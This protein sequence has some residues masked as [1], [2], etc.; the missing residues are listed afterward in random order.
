MRNIC[1]LPL[2]IAL[3]IVLT[4][5]PTT[6]VAQDAS[7]YMY[8]ANWGTPK[9]RRANLDGTNIQDLVTGIS[10]PVDIAL[11]LP[12]GKMYWTDRTADDH[13]DPNIMNRI[14]RANLDGTNI[15]TLAIGRSSIKEG[16]ALDLSGGKMYWAVWSVVN[17]ENKIQRANLDGTN[18]EDLVILP[19]ADTSRYTGPRGIALDISQG[20]M[21]WTD[22]G[23]GKIQRA[24]LDGTNIE[25]LV[26]GLGCPHRIA[27]DFSGDKVYWTD[28]D[29]EKI[30]RANLNGSNPEDIIVGLS[31]PTGI[32][33]DSL[34]GK[35]YW[36]DAGTDII[37]RANMDGTNVET[38]VI[39][40]PGLVSIALSIPQVRPGDGLRFN[41]NVIADQTFTVG[42]YVNLTL[43]TATGGTAPYAYTLA[44]IPNGLQFDPATRELRGVPITDM[45]ATPVTYT[46][47]DTA[48]RTASL[49]F[50]ITVTTAFAQDAPIYVYWADRNP[51]KIRRA[52]LDG[53]NVRDLVTGLGRPVGIALDLAGGKM[54]WTDRD[55]SNFRDPNARTKILRA[56]ID[57]SNIETLVTGPASTLLSEEIALDLAAGKMYWTDVGDIDGILRANLDG[58][59]IETLV[60]EVSSLRGIAL[61]L[62]DGK[63]YWSD[64]GE[65]KIQRANL[66]GSNIETLVPGLGSPHHIAL[67]FNR[68]RIYWTT[69][70][71]GKIQRANF[72]GSNLE[73]VVIGLVVCHN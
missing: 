36:V 52:N 24:N 73:D 30:Q 70:R 45:N 51:G 32:A 13:R 66:D 9:I 50:D 23:G 57:G 15:E 48:G 20:K 35:M 16:I 40:S 41:P 2:L 44:P 17:D 29:T 1:S 53:T 68:D 67:D 33:L 4:F 27:L 63:M 58:T 39:E 10:R 38:L 21:Y 64:P 49:T 60:T 42:T 6:S 56:N 8:W 54:Y 71:V 18:V 3:F 34:N 12:T 14:L 26:T 61:D 62:T 69:D 31:R 11:D 43:P 65:G 59:N 19:T 47:T 72:D 25:D 46:A 5:N 22:C 37:R 55:N 28:Y 7:V